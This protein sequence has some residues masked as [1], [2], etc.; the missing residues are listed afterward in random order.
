VRLLFRTVSRRI[1][2]TGYFAAPP[3]AKSS[4]SVFLLIIGS[5]IVG[6]LTQ[7]V[8]TRTL[9]ATEY[10][11]YAIAISWGLLVAAPTMAGLDASILRFASRYFEF[12]LGAQLRRFAW[13]IAFIQLAAIL[14]SAGAVLLTPIRDFALSG[15]DRRGVIWLILF[16]GSTAFL[17]SFSVFFTA[18]RKFLF[19]QLYQNFVRPGLLIMGILIAELIG[20]FA[21]R[22]DS[23]LAMTAIT[24]AAA[25]IM[26][27][28]HLVFAFRR[29][30]ASGMTVAE[31]RRWVSFSGWAQVG[32][33][34]QLSVP[35]IPV[36][37]LG[38]FSTP[39]EAGFYAVAA[40]LS[41]LVTFGLSAVG[42]ASAPLISSAHERGDWN[43]IAH[44]ARVAA[45]LA[46]AIA[47]CAI[48]FFVLVG[49]HV[50]GVFGHGFSGAYAP[51]MVLLVG[52]FINAFCGVNV[53]LLSMTDRPAFA[54][55]AL[56]AGAVLNVVASYLL[57]PHYGAVGGAVGTSAGLMLSNFLMVL[58]IY[59]TMGIDSTAIGARPREAGHGAA[60]GASKAPRL[61][62]N[63]LK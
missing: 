19:S 31:T 45:R 22:A 28:A 55:G 54:V 51:L 63:L 26:L 38:G 24:S 60:T 20:V 17:G 9:G 40:R 53:I 39:A 12:G 13:F 18:F 4:A 46:T 14:L 25:L 33:L 44:L 41:A 32:S 34:A 52:A 29:A 3:L 43:E 7:V 42:T 59:T 27:L 5:A 58:R 47:C 62:P 35:Q 36:I 61:P 21:V 2:G 6:L 15:S 23:A 10:G 8:L 56:F 50:M 1:R 49:A 37:L 57:I 30:G 16:I 11:R 48:L